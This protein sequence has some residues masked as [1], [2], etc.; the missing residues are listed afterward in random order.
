MR[1]ILPVIL[2]LWVGGCEPPTYME[3]ETSGAGASILPA[4]LSPVADWM[5]TRP[6][7][8]DRE[9]RQRERTAPNGRLEEKETATKWK[10]VRK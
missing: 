3:V 5:R 1:K 9:F 4:L 2:A 6:H 8:E 7:Q 10:I